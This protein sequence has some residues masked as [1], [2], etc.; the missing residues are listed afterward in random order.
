MCIAH[1]SIEILI[2]NCASQISEQNTCSIL[3]QE[4][5]DLSAKVG[6]LSDELNE[7]MNHMSA[8]LT[9]ETSENTRLREELEHTKRALKYFQGNAQVSSMCYN[10]IWMKVE[11][12]SQSNIV[13]IQHKW[14]KYFI[15]IQD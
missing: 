4:R 3:S 2:S 9:R 14:P 1:C 6:A 11:L 7:R 8:L 13:Q 10:E 15:T 12:H 5:S